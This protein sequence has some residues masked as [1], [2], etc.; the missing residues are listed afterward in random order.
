M[1]I[2]KAA[3][4]EQRKR[5]LRTD[6]HVGQ[7]CG[8]RQ[9]P[10]MERLNRVGQWAFGEEDSGKGILIQHLNR[11]EGCREEINEL[12]TGHFPKVIGICA[13]QACD[14]WIRRGDKEQSI[15]A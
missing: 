15:W 14:L 4:L 11:F 13:I 10:A 7:G 12:F 8:L 6:G 1:G 2:Q 5:S 3:V 9:R